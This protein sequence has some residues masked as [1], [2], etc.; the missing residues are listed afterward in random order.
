M[1]NF[2]PRFLQSIIALAFLFLGLQQGQAQLD[3]QLSLDDAFAKGNFIE[4][5]IN[6][7]G[8]FGVPNSQNPGPP[9]HDSRETGNDL[10]GFIANP[11]MDGWVDYDGDFFTPGSPEEGWAIEYDG[12]T[13]NNNLASPNQVP[14]AVSGAGILTD[15]CFGDFAQV[16]W[17]GFIDGIEIIRNFSVSRD[18]L[19]IRMEQRLTNLDDVPKTNLYWMNNVDPDNNQTINGSF[20]T[21]QELIAQ[22][23][24]GL[25]IL[26]FVC[27]SQGPLGGV[28]AN[29][30]SVC[31][32]VQD[33]RARVTYGG[34]T[35]QK[36]R[37]IQ[38]MRLSLS[39]TSLG[40]LLREN[41]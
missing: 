3:A 34:F 15:P 22:P 23:S 32:Y 39:P 14:G 37:P 17:N 24:G 31:Y 33:E 9:Y 35:K 10:F 27:A 13:W 25:D 29:G 40:I 4:I 12:A 6:Q 5:G 16:S 38:Q 21:D 26:G 8:T 11:V 7:N 18:G 28:D 36:E 41:L 30:S 19:F 1:R 20:T 2:T